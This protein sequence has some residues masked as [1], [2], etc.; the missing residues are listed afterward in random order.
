MKRRLSPTV[1]RMG[2]LMRVRYGQRA[3]VATRERPHQ[4]Q[5]GI[6]GVPARCGRGSLVAVGLSLPWISR[7]R[8]SLAAVGLSRPWVSRGRGYRGRGSRGR[9]SRGSRGCR[10]RSGRG[11]RGRLGLSGRRLSGPCSRGRRGG[12]LEK[13]RRAHTRH[14]K[15]SVWSAQRSKSIG[16][17]DA[18]AGEAVVKCACKRALGGRLTHRAIAR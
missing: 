8:E 12:R 2:R 18:A 13:L 5:S 9:G 16:Q 4:E 10:S 6:A 15:V 7:C 11:S 3:S 17:C 1:R 14:A